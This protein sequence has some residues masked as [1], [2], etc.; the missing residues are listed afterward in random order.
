MAQWVDDLRQTK[1]D[2][3]DPSGDTLTSLTTKIGDGATTVVA[4]L[5]SI[6]AD[7]YDGSVKNVMLNRDMPYLTELWATEAIN[8][9]YW[10]TVTDGASTA[11]F[12]EAAGYMYADLD[13]DA[14]ADD[15]VMLNGKYRWQV[16]PSVFSDTN[17]PVEA[18]DLEFEL[19]II[20]AVTEHD[21][22]HFFLGLA[23]SKTNDITTQDIIGFYLNGDNLR[24][25]TDSGGV[26]SETGNITATLTQ[27][28]KFKIR[29]SE[30]SLV[31]SFNGTAETAITTNIADENMY[32]IFGTRAEAAAT[33]GL[34]VGTVRA[35]YEEA[36]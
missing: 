8:G 17:T 32:L 27:W 21:N 10:E 33:V 26:E 2:V 4:D 29:V 28:N 3:G 19:Q 34:N 5:A 35:W 11:V 18:F 15:D 23:P 9:A 25:M 16:R 12:G 1:T 13:T 30:D 20:T 14:V 31:F 7:L 36:V 22:T 24:G 6:L